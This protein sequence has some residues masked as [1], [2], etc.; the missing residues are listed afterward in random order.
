MGAV[1]G[2]LSTVNIKVPLLTYWTNRKTY[3]L[4]QIFKMQRPIYRSTTN[5]IKLSAIFFKHV[6]ELGKSVTPGT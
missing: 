2:A 3:R 6:N 1:C 4:M 5:F